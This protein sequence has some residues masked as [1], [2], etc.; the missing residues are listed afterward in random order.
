MLTG[1]KGETA[2][3]IGFSCGLIQKDK[4]EVITLDETPSQ[5]IKDT[6]NL[7]DKALEKSLATQDFG[8][9]IGGDFLHKTLCSES[10]SGKLL[11]IFMKA[12]S[13]IVYRC[14][15]AQ[16][17]EIVTLVKTRVKDSITLAI[18]DGANDVNMIQQAHVGIGIMGKE[19]N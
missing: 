10:E 12:S 13:V 17:A 1:D 11:Q 14:S 15:P 5:L 7:L 19:G 8:L 18:G 9:L 3:E 6:I 16:K 2:Q 4:Q